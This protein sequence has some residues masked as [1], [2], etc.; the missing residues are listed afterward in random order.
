MRV[1][2]EELD[3]CLGRFSGLDAENDSPTLRR[4]DL[5]R[6]VR[7]RREVNERPAHRSK[8]GRQNRRHGL[9]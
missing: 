1:G 7:V 2:L 3:S 5:V 4:R 9:G 8:A 6:V